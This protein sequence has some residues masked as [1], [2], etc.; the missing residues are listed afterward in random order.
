VDTFYPFRRILAGHRKW[1][2]YREHSQARITRANWLP[3]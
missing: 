2:K 3:C 1:R